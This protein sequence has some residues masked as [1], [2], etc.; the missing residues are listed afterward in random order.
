MF[1]KDVKVPLQEVELVGTYSSNKSF[2]ELIR[3]EQKQEEN[4][5]AMASD[6]CQSMIK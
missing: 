6:G 4:Y 2:D 1:N 3:L 5:K